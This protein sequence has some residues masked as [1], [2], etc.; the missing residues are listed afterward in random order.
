MLRKYL[1]LQPFL[2]KATFDDDLKAKISAVSGVD[3]DIEK[4]TSIL[5]EFNEL[6]VYLQKESSEVSLSVVCQLFDGLI[7]ETPRLRQ[8]IGSNAEIVHDKCF[9]SGVV[10]PERGERSQLQKL[11]LQKFSRKLTTVQW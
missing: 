7:A 4:L 3:K 5:V 8:Y 9:E 11:E 2:K 6:S 10:K 1:K